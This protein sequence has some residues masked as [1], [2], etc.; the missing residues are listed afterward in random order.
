[1]SKVKLAYQVYDEGEPEYVVVDYI[2]EAKGGGN[3]DFAVKH[4]CVVDGEVIQSRTNRVYWSGKG[5]DRAGHWNLRVPRG[6]TCTAVVIDLDAG[7]AELTDPVE[8]V[9]E[10][11]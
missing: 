10:V 9:A 6:G 2:V 8:Y 4:E 11:A 7:K 5:Q 3:I 1:M